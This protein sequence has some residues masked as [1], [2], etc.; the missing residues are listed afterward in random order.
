MDAKIDMTTFQ[1]NY[2]GRWYCIY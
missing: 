1:K 2:V